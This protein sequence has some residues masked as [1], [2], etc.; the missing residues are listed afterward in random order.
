MRRSG[1]KSLPSIL[2][3]EKPCK[4]VAAPSIVWKT[5]FNELLG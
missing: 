1:G 2:R 3:L 4:N 5:T